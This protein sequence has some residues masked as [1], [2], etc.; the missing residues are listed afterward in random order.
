MRNNVSYTWPTD[1]PKD[2][3]PNGSAPADGYVYRF[4][5][6]VPPTADDF[7]MYRIDNPTCDHSIRKEG[8]TYGLSL[9]NRLDRIQKKKLLYP[10]PEQFGNK[11]IVGGE[12]IPELG[13]TRNT[14]T[15]N[16]ITL[17]KQV[18]AEPHLH[19]FKEEL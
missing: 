6:T 5:S 13:A 9:W 8:I 3:P 1:Y 18:D 11:H 7:N 15:R 16:H 14:L 12:L 2:T 10:K 4:A 17:W 19:I